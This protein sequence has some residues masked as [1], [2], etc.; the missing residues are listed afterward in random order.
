MNSYNRFTPTQ[1][2]KAYEWLK[3]QYAAGTRQKPVKCDS[4]TQTEGI[5]EPHSENYG[6]PYGDHIGQYGLCYRCHMA[7][8]TRFKNLASFKRYA[9][10]VLL[11]EVAQPFYTRDFQTFAKQHLRG[12]SVPVSHHTEETSSLLMDILNANT[13]Q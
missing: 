4:C 11:G 6:A 1:R 2:M 9:G 10:N 3:Q 8:H 13:P 5:I 12:Y 7:L